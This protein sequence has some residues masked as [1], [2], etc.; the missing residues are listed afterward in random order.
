V[1]KVGRKNSDRKRD[2]DKNM[3]KEGETD[4]KKPSKYE[5]LR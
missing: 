3:G 4:K 1:G 2:E 5:Y